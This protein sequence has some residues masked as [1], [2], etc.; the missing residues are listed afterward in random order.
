MGKSSGKNFTEGWI[1]F[2]D[3]RV[4]KQTAQML[5]GQPM[6]GKRRSAYHYDLWCLKYLSKFKWDHLTEEI[7]KH[8][9]IYLKHTPLQDSSVIPRKQRQI[10]TP[11]GI[12]FTCCASCRSSRCNSAE[13]HLS[14]HLR[15]CEMVLQ[16]TRR[17]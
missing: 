14:G 4:A 1:E 7:G 17:L 11:C 16:R 6:G 10:A 5:N 3:K 2:E 9:Q 12:L 15:S 13:G 8:E